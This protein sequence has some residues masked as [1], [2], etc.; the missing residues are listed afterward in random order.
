VAGVGSAPDG[1]EEAG[2]VPDVLAGALGGLAHEV[3]VLI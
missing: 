2:W 3:S 1:V